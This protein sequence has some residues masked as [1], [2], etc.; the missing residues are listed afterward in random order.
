MNLSDEETILAIQEN[1][2]MQYML[3]LSEFSDKPVF[4]PSLFVTIRKRLQIEDPNSFILSLTKAGKKEDDASD[5]SDNDDDTHNG[6]IKM[7]PPAV[8]PKSAILRVLI[9]WMMVA[10]WSIDILINFAENIHSFIL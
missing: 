6:D 8:M 3:G 2:Y 4:D 1:P 10:M 7:M 9:Y 5:N